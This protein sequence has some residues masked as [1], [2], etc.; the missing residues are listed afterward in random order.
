M[1]ALIVLIVLAVIALIVVS[2]INR[3]QEKERVRR[4]KQR[5]LRIRADALID[6]LATLEQT[7][8]N[9]LIARYINDEIVLLCRQI[10]ELENGPNPRAEASL[11]ASIQ[12]SNDL[13]SGQVTGQARYQKDSDAQ[14]A[15]TL[16]HLNEVG[17]VLRHL[18]AQGK[19][20]T[21]VL[22][23]FLNELS[24]AHLMVSVQSYIGQ[25][26]KFSA[27]QDRLSAHNYYQRAHTMLLE[28][29]H[30]DPRRLRMI[31]ELSE[32]LEGSRKS[33]S[34]DLMP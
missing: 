12:H 11:R 17:A 25:G 18:C 31:K 15:Q 10:L 26:Y 33:M 4:F 1:Y 14:I 21:D 22:D 7:L 5:K 16:T 23:G 6:V 8:P 24:W 28:S 30:T 27:L 3:A 32:M 13:A 2:G 9:A 34:V 20:N 19:L 29:L